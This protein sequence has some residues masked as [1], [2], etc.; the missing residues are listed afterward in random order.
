MRIGLCSWSLQPT[1]PRD[2]ADKAQAVGVSCVQLALDPLRTGAWS[3][4]ETR[5]AL[6]AAGLTIAS[7]MMAMQSEDYSTLESIKRTGGVAPD[8]TWPANLHAAQKNAQIA[9]ELAL[10]LVTFHAGFIPHDAGDPQRGVI[11]DRLRQLADVYIAAGVRVAFET[12]QETADTLLA[13]LEELDRP[14][15]GVNFDPANMILYAM[16]DPVAALGRLAPRI[17]QIH[18]KDAIATRTPGTWG[19]EVPVGTG[20]VDWPA[21]FDV[22][23]KA[24][25]HCDLIIEREAGGSR[26]E[27]IRA[28]LALIGRY[29]S[30]P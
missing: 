7:G 10:P 3:L 21:F 23:R 17:A 2:L 15:V 26:V 13:A 6:G 1:S 20:D 12:G 16:G 19:S 9:A 18:V 11:L 30:R 24:D 5:D 22:I 4:V 8:G 14:E 25:L 27:D 29:T 28:A